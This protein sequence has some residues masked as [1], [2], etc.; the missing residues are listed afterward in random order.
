M[1]IMSQYFHQSMKSENIY[2]DKIKQI[3][4]LANL[5]SLKPNQNI[6]KTLSKKLEEKTKN[7]WKQNLD[8]FETKQ[9]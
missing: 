6:A 7:E 3:S 4:A 9:S 5:F 8:V 1:E 2:K